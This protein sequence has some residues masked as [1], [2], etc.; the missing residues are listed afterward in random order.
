MKPIAQLVPD[1]AAFDRAVVSG[2]HVAVSLTVKRTVL[3][4]RVQHRWRNRSYDTA[5]SINSDSQATG[6]GSEGHVKAGRIAVYMNDGTRPHIIAARRKKALRFVQGGAVRFA[7]SV[8]HPG[9][10]ADPYLEAA[11]E[12]AG[13]E[14]DRAVGALL[15]A[16]L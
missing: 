16:L 4:A 9:T 13:A 3:K 8:K 1:A 10:K 5:A 12:Y 11:Q 15:D 14:I 2:L 6:N 7:K